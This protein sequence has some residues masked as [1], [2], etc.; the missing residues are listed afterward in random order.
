MPAGY[1]GAIRFAIAPYRNSRGDN[2]PKKSNP[3]PKN[4]SDNAHASI[5]EGRLPEAF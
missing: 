1:N 2:F 5:H 3:R 4:L